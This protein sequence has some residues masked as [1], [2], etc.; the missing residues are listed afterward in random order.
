MNYTEKHH[1][2]QWEETDRILRVDFN[3]MCADMEAGLEKNAR[4][5]EE[6]LSAA[7]SKPTSAAVTK[8]QSTADRALGAAETAQR[9]AAAAQAAANNAYSPSN[10][11]FAIGTYAGDSSRSDRTISVGFRPRF[12]AILGEQGGE[13]SYF[14]FAAEGLMYNS[15]VPAP[16]GFTLR[17]VCADFSRV[18]HQGKKYTYIAFP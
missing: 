7:N 13:V 2:P 9:Q 10:K 15:A 12:V 6:A 14:D 18:N 8:A 4:A 3:Q 11:P 17:G 1:L 16:G 5:A